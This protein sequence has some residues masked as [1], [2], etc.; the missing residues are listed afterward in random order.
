MAEVHGESVMMRRDFKRF[1]SPV[2]MHSSSR[3]NPSLPNY[4]PIEEF[5]DDEVVVIENTK[6]GRRKMESQGFII[7]ST[8]GN[9]LRMVRTKL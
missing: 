7:Q 2:D 4:I 8:E 5:E 9:K 1:Y 3:R 6:E